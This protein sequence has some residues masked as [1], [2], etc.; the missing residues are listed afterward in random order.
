MSTEA[1]AVRFNFAPGPAQLPAAVAAEVAEAVRA[2]PPSGRSLLEL[3]HHS[4][5]FAEIAA[6][7]EADLRALLGIGADH[8]VLFGNGGARLHYA[9]WP[10]NLAAA[11]AA[12]GYVDTGHW[13]RLA[14]AEARCQRRRVRVFDADDAGDYPEVAAADAAECA[15]VH[16]V[17]N[18]TLTGLAM[19]PPAVACPLVCDST[20]DFLS[21]PLD[22][23]R[24]ALVY[25][26]CQKNLGAAGL[27]VLIARIDR[28][29]EAEILP[30]G[31]RYAE[32]IAARGL[33][34]TPPI[35]PWFVA[36]RML[37][38]LRAEGGL[39][40]MRRRARAR[41]QPLYECIDA[42]GPY[43]NAIAPRARSVMNVCFQ[44][45]DAAL[46]ER[47]LRRAA[48][49]GLAGLRGHPAAGGVR[50][51]LYNAMPEAGADALLQFMREFARTA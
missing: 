37:R 2:Y 47:F 14:L 7:A 43:R 10:P 41:A 28:L 29:Q 45:P 36:A 12:L 20:S 46:E 5:A 25:A 8:A 24:F 30:K 4:D 16:Y 9:L 21:A 48:A 49:Q 51:S 18:E 39:D 38:W 23:D 15:L 26:G 27:T 11:D 19:P 42:A 44:L 13:S 32:Q 22:I 33:G 50:A 31:F 1:P 34:H 40:E 17:S 6:T 35:V 3:S